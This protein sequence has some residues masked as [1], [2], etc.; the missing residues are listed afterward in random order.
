MT[1]HHSI[2]AV[3]PGE[4]LREDVLPAVKLSKAAIA[5]ALGISRQHLYDI[6]NE[7]QPVS[8]EMAVRFGKLLGNGPRL[9]INLQRNYDL[10]VAESRVDVSGIPT[11]E[12]E[13]D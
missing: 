10:A 2:R 12:A 3:H 8:A 11:L 13:T 9:W 7:R 5:R 4:V 6:L 1:A